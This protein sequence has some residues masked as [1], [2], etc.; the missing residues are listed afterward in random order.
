VPAPPVYQPVVGWTGL[1]WLTSS[2][3]PS[4]NGHVYSFTRNP[5][6]D[7]RLLRVYAKD[8]YPQVR[9]VEDILI[10]AYYGLFGGAQLVS[11]TPKGISYPEVMQSITLGGYTFS[12][13]YGKVMV[14]AQGRF[15]SVAEAFRQGVLANE[16]IAAIAGLFNSAAPPALPALTPEQALRIK[17]DFLRSLEPEY[18]VNALANNVYLRLRRD[19]TVDFNAAGAAIWAGPDGAIGTLDDRVLTLREGSFFYEES[20]GVWRFVVSRYHYEDPRWAAW[21]T[22]TTTTAAPT[23]TT[24]PTGSIAGSTSTTTS[25]FLTTGGPDAP[26]KTGVPLNAGLFACVAALFMGCLYCGY[27]VAKKEKA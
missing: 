19:G 18:Y 2:Y 8:L 3:N 4:I 13:P 12:V 22:P 7:T 23:T 15:Y 25:P 16:A 24:G 1:Y 9:T 17:E 21:D 14:Y 5:A 27:R 10:G 26:P 20:P 11:I 6:T